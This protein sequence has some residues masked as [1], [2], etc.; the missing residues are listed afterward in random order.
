MKQFS[1]PKKLKGVFR[2]LLLILCGVILGV[3]V[4]LANANSL[5]GNQ[6]PMPFGYG[7]T[8]VLS[9][10][11][12]P[13]FSKGDLIV[14]NETDTYEVNDIVVFQDGNSL[15]VHRII[16]IDGETITTKGDANKSADE[17]INISAVKG[18]VLFWIPYA[19]SVVGF[20]KTPVGIICII[21]AAVALIE[22]PRRNEKKKDD[23]ER[24]KIIEEIE[25]FKKDRESYK[26]GEAERWS[27]TTKQR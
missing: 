8:V 23:E 21:A 2:L 18:K 10:S 3:N 11:M 4:Y 9:G 5:V 13:E 15:V 12:E 22:I 19:G 6:L 20:L 1:K 16:N 14:V 26:R 7:A 27:H 24:Q 25:R 17:P